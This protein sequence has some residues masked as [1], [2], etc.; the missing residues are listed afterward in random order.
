MNTINFKVGFIMLTATIC[1]FISCSGDDSHGISA[2]I[3]DFTQEVL[4]GDSAS[5]SITINGGK[6]PYA[7]RYSY[8][9]GETTIVK[10]IIDIPEQS[11]T[12]KTLPSKDV[13]YVAHAVASYGLVGG[14]SGRADIKVSP[15]KYTFSESIPASKT[16]FMQRS[17]NELSYS[18][19]LQL[20]SSNNNNDRTVFFEFD[21]S[22]FNEVKDKSRYNLMF[23]LVQSHS[24]GLNIPSTMTVKAVLGELDENMTWDSQPA[25]LDLT[26]LFTQDFLTAATTDQIKFEG[27]INPIIY[28]AIQ[29][30]V[31]KITFV[32][33]ELDNGGLYYIGSDTYSDETQRPMI[34]M[35]YREKV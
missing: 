26:S 2:S 28:E 19:L 8:F 11:F 35:Y 4:Q 29:N 32:V 31:D 12:F 30:N 34:D 33:R 14:A 15:V 21:I 6:P 7:F 1:T 5:V 24:V 18:E 9:N 10:N 27:N 3:T 25:V 22:Q 16:A 17:K 13:S 23:W 20:R